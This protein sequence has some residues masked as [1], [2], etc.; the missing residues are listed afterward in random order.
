MNELE[1]LHVP[2]E[3]LA[4]LC[5][6][7]GVVELSVFGSALRPDFRPDS[8]IDLLVVFEKDRPVGLP[9]L[10]PTASS[11]ATRSASTSP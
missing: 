5:R 4:A 1:R 11:T 6:D 2:A 8:D 3:A 9:R 7:F 10:S